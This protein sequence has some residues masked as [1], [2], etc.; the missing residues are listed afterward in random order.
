M[1]GI[2]FLSVIR[3]LL[4]SYQSPPPERLSKAGEGEGESQWPSMEEGEKAET[5]SGIGTLDR[6]LRTLLLGDTLHTN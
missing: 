1:S 2:V 3:L 4:Y 5:R 6:G